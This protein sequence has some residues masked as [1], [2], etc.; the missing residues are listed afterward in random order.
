[1]INDIIEQTINY[2]IYAEGDRYLGTATIDL[3][4]F[5]YLTNEISG[6]GIA[7]KIDVPTLGHWENA[8]VTAHWRNIFERPIWLLDQD[9]VMLSFRSAVQQYDAATGIYTVLPVRIDVRALAAGITLGKLEPGEQSETESKFNIDYI[10]VQVGDDVLLEADKFNFVYV[11]NGRD[12]L[13]DV[14]TALG[15]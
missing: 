3:P 1:M 8:E 9:A 4:E 13:A 2:E 15:L 10:K 7:G 11:V 6:A 12:H 14:R 5:N